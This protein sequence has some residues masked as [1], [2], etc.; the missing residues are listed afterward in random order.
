MAAHLWTGEPP[1]KEYVILYLCRLYHCTP[2][3]LAKEDS[4]MVLAH[5]TC[6]KWEQEVDATEARARKQ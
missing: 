6:V 4:N 1:P 5:L 3:Q 2:S